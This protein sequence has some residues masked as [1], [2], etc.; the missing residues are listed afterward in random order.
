MRFDVLGEFVDLATTLNFTETSKRC[1]IAQP[2]LSKHIK[3]LEQELGVSLLVRDTRHVELTAVGKR[4]LPYAAA[5]VDNANRV[6]A[7]ATT[8]RTGV[9]E[10]ISVGYLRVAAE[11]AIPEAHERFKLMHPATNVSYTPF[12]Y[13]ELIRSL[14][15]G[16]IDIA[17][18]MRTFNKNELTDYHC[19][20]LFVDEMAIVVPKSH[21]LFRKKGDSLKPKDL[22]GSSFL[23]LPKGTLFSGDEPLSV[24]LDRIGVRT[25]RVE[26]FKELET[27]PLQLTT[28][29]CVSY[30][31]FH[32]HPYFDEAGLGLFRFF[33]LEGF[34]QTQTFS[35]VWKKA[36]EKFGLSDYARILAETF[37]ELKGK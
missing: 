2:A 29:N 34:R 33:R 24:F 26:R 28:E 5:C 1:H 6:F 18:G 7:L 17:V 3:S 23:T 11:K 35:I 14:E 36:N 22:S 27:L 9:G 20:D 19:I 30:L 8:F 13:Y 31:P 32:L 12:S 16:E 4:I 15:N 25:T 37:F 21:K 10:T